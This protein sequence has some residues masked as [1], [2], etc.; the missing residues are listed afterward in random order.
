MTTPITFPGLTGTV[1]PDP[2]AGVPEGFTPGSRAWRCTLTYRAGDGETRTGSFPYFTGPAITDPPT[3]EEVAA[4]LARDLPYADPEEADGLGL[5]IRQW[6]AV[7][8]IAERVRAL[9]GPDLDAFTAWAEE[10]DA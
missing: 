1:H 4:D 8:D 6:L 2:G 7:R 3:P 5:S 9:I 10:V